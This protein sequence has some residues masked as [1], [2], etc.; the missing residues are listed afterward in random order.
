MAWMPALRGSVVCFTGVKRE[1]Y[2]FQFPLSNGSVLDCEWIADYIHGLHTM[3]TSAL[4]LSFP[5]TL[6]TEI[7]F[8]Q[9]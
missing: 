2:T 5:S 7:Q 6:P 3:H 4:H 1:V 9:F 8:Q